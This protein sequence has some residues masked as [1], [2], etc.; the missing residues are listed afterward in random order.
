LKDPKEKGIRKVLNF[1]HT[2]GHAIESYFLDNNNKD[3]LTHG[4]AIA[5]GMVCESYL[6]YKVL[7]LP[8]EKLNIV[9]NMISTM[10]EKVTIVQEDYAPIFELLKHDKKNNNGEVNFVLLNDFEE[11]KLDCKI[12][13]KLLIESIE[14]YNS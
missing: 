6:S 7:K 3:N 5:I 12:S 13:N 8:I 4:E 11:F 9:K 1:G 14:Y 10:Y 2:L